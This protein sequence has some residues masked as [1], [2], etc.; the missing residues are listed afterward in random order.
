M[1]WCAPTLWKNLPPPNYHIFASPT[2]PLR[3]HV[4]STLLAISIIQYSVINYNPHVIYWILR[5]EYSPYNSKFVLLYKTLISLISQQPLFYCFYQL[6]VCCLA[7]FFLMIPHINDTTQ[8]LPLYIWL[9][10]LSIMPSRLNYVPTSKKKF[11]L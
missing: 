6:K 11:F 9:I 1:Y 3:I 10:S 5:L 8:C 7:F 2:H 4:S